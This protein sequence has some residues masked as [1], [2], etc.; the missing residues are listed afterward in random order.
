[1]ILVQLL[2]LNCTILQC[3]VVHAIHGVKPYKLAFQ[4]NQQHVNWIFQ[5]GVIAKTLKSAQKTNSHTETTQ[6]LISW[7]LVHIAYPFFSFRV[8][9]SLGGLFLV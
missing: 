4:R 7:K 8:Y 3:F 1:M 9:T 5:D 2:I 6:K